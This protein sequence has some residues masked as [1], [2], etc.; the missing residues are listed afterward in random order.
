[1]T[2]LNQ[3]KSL[4]RDGDRLMTSALVEHLKAA[5]PTSGAS[6]PIPTQSSLGCWLQL[7]RQAFERPRFLDWARRQSLNLADLRVHNGTL[8]TQSETFT[9]DDQSD[10]YQLAPPILAISRVLDPDAMGLPFPGEHPALSARQILRFYGYPQPTTGALRG[11]LIDTLSQLQSFFWRAESPLSEAFKQL[12][13]DRQTVAQQLVAGIEAED[14]NDRAFSLFT[15]YRIRCWLT[16]LSFWATSMATASALLQG[17]TEHPKFLALEQTRD[18][19]PEHYLFDVTRQSIRGAGPSGTPLE[20]DYEHLAQLP[21][22]GVFER[23]QALANAMQLSI[24]LDGKFNLAQLLALHELPLPDT[25]EAAWDLIGQ[26]R[27]PSPVSVP[28]ICDQADSD[29]AMQVHR[30][31]LIIERER[32]NQAHAQGSRLAWG[33]PVK[34]RLGNYWEGL[35]LPQSGALTLSA[36]QRVTVVNI[37]RRFLPQPNQGLLELLSADL[38]PGPHEEQVYQLLA[39]PAA[40][41]LADQLID[42]MQWYG[43]APGQLAN[44]SSRDTLVLSALILDLDPQAGQTRYTLAGLNLNH[45][46]CWGHRYTDLRRTV[47]LHL[48]ESGAATSRSTALAAHLLLAGIAPEFLVG[49]LPDSLYFMTSHAWLLLKQ[50]VMLAEA[51][52]CGSSRHL[53]FNDIVALATQELDAA[54]QPLWRTH[55]TTSTLIDWGLAQGQLPSGD[56]HDTYNLENIHTLQNTL[57]ARVDAL[58]DASKTLR[59]TLVTR[60]RIALNDLKKIFRGN[61]LLKRKCLRWGQGPLRRPSYLPAHGTQ[62]QSL[63]DLHMSGA[64]QAIAQQWNSVDP[65]LNLTE[66]KQHFSRLN[67]VNNL[68]QEA[69]VAHVARLKEAYTT[70]IRYLLAQLPFKDREHLQKA[71]VQ[72]LVLRQPANKPQIEEQPGQKMART[73]RFGLILRCEELN[74]HHDYELFPLLNLAYKN[75]RLPHTLDLGGTPLTVKTGSPHSTQPTSQLHLGSSLALDEAAYMTGSPPRADQ[76]STVIIDRL[77]R[78]EASESAS[79]ALTFDS[80]RAFTLATA[81]VNQHFFLDIDAL[82]VQ[83]RG[84]TLQEDRQKTAEA[85]YQALLGLIPLWS[86]TQDLA[87]GDTKRMIA[88]AYGCFF[89]VFG[90]L[91]PTKGLLLTGMA[92]LGKAAPAYI[93]LLQLA[94]LGATYLNAVFNPFDSLPSLLR[95]GRHGLVRLNQAGMRA[96]EGAVRHTRLR[97]APG[98]AVDYTRLLNRADI[99]PATLMHADGVTQVLA[100][101]RASA[102]YAFDPISARPYGP[103][104]A[105][106]RLDTAITVIPYRS[107]DGYKA[108]MTE[109]LFDKP[110]LLIQ[111]ANATDLLDQGR[112]WRLPHDGATHMNELTSPTYARQVD[113]FDNLCTIRRNKRSPVPIVCFTKKLHEYAHSIHLRRVQALDHVRLIPAPLAGEQ[114]RQLVYYR[115]IH[116]VTPRVTEFELT[117]LPASAPLT[118]KTHIT[119]RRIDNEP[120]FGLPVDDLDTVLSRQTQVVELDGIVDGIN[121][122]RT[123]RALLVSVPGTDHWVVEADVGVFYRVPAISIGPGA[124][125]FE[126]LDYSVGGEHVALIDAFGERKNQ[127]LKAAERLPD[128]PLVALPTLEVLYRQLARRGVSAEKI[129]RVRERAASLRTIKQRELLLH[130]SDQG[131]SLN[132]N[133]VSRPVQLDIWPPRPDTP[134]RPTAWQINRHLAEKA[135]ASTSA[136][137]ERTQL[138]SA[139]VQGPTLD[140]LRRVQEAQSVVMWEYSKIGQPHYTEIILKT[141]AGNCDQMAHAACEMIRTNGGTAQVWVCQVHTFVVV[142]TL[143]AGLNLTLDFQESGWADLWISDPWAAITCPAKE[144]MRTLH[145]KMLTWDLEDIAVFFNDGNAYRWARANDPDW[146]RLL[147]TT[148]KQPRP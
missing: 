128:Q 6:L 89:D 99:A 109:T 33:P 115:C 135:N 51:L 83:A 44:R 103:P 19:D 100:I 130:L 105:D 140:E 137:I 141:G 78:V 25:R 39:R 62:L 129:E 119:G 58:G 132:F 30:Q 145:I 31:S 92:R 14:D 113:T 106:L 21:L 10:W 61:R 32:D 29:M 146:L 1:M 65:A 15:L 53:R 102:W 121:D 120:Q 49:K 142:G 147:L 94:T 81:I 77:W 12:E 96:L 45:R 110:P 136:L 11:A 20:I 97:L 9:L 86:C 91:A 66:M 69:S 143:P 107:V 95:L 79:Q 127:F 117:P 42:A 116:E 68:F 123:L 80:P 131:R 36:E 17:I 139:N 50:G 57:T 41:I 8:H 138:K 60:R 87:S 134:A 108:R 76:S 16:S 37:T 75:L 74:G 118:Y 125:R 38:L 28:P 2:P 3:S 133:F 82:V 72:L 88:G 54:E 90:L 73:G 43:H 124:L 27:R 55:Y 40:Q 67:N 13:E 56:E 98:A 34:P 24:S 5:T 144:Y 84:S 63:V 52:A 122:S 104:L 48:I 35:G 101:K 22:D 64:L 23:L 71:A 47:E 112:V 126:Q 111:R 7:Y 148:P 4:R 26:L 114:K 70:V 93:K 85:V 59:T 46:D 18:L